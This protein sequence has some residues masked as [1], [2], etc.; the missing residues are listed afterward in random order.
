MNQRMGRAIKEKTMG[1]VHLLDWAYCATLAQS[2]AIHVAGIM[3][4]WP[5]HCCTCLRMS[6]GGVRGMITW[7]QDVGYGLVRGEVRAGL[8][9]VEPRS[10]A[11]GT[12]Q[13]ISTH[14]FGLYFTPYQ[15]RSLLTLS[16]PTPSCPHIVAPQ[17]L[18][19]IHQ[20]D[21]IKHR[22]SSFPQTKKENLYL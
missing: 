21:P 1:C 11:A 13:D 18:V 16:S 22:S 15:L 14:P 19:H 4:I 6:F 2:I 5:M 8:D 9:G 3:S 12:G 17:P 20:D 10:V 7:Q